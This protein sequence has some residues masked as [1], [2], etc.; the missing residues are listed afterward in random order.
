MNEA[1]EERAVP[2]H[3]SQSGR[4][5]HNYAAQGIPILGK[6]SSGGMYVIVIGVPV[7]APTPDWTYAPPQPASYRRGFNWPAFNWRVFAQLLAVLMIAAALGYFGWVFAT[8]SDASGGDIVAGAQDAAGNFTAW[9]DDRLALLRP[10]PRGEPVVERTGFR[11]PWESA[12]VSAPKAAGGSE[13]WMPAN[14]VGDAV[15][16]IG[17]MITWLVWALVIVGVLWVVSLLTPILLRL[18]R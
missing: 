18:R 9:L 10:L 15:D 14:P 5:M 16:G 3:P 12:V 1:Y 11:W 4:A 2:V 6:G 17:R 13:W 7:G 8:G